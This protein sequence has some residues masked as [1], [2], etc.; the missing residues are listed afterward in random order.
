MAGR[1]EM[2]IVVITGLS[3]AGKTTAVQ[4]LEDLGYYC[5]DNLPPALIPKF[6]ELCSQAEGKITRVALVIDIRGRKFFDSLSEALHTLDQQGYRYQILFLEAADEVLVRRFKESRRR[7]PL[8]PLGRVLE[9]ITTERQ[10]LQE[11]RGRASKII[12]TSNLSVQEL[13][14]QIMEIFGGR[15]GVSPLM[16]TVIS[17]GYKYGIPMDAD[18]VFDVR[19]LPNPFYVRELRE[20]TGREKEVREFVL[21]HRVTQMFL[22]RFTNLLVFLLPLYIKEG[23]SHLGVAIGCTGGQHRS[24]VLADEIGKALR[25]RGYQVIVKHRDLP[26]EF[27]EKEAKGAEE[28]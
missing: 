26:R 2:N 27:A 5:V 17:F 10:W 9:G 21:R 12:D 4:C 25:K 3:G 14:E 11:L 22:R 6:A 16:V 20:Y 8:A 24:V 28:Q 23:K 7:H 15:G 18:L 13:K 1:S 19:F